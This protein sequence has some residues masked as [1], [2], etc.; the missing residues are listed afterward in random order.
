MAAAAKKI[1][2]KS[3]ASR[4]GP[5]KV[6]ISLHDEDVYAALLQLQDSLNEA[7]ARFNAHTHTGVTAG[8]GSTGTT[9]APITG[10]PQTATN[11]FTTP[12][13]T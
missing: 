8:A 9:S 2:R 4:P 12:A 11:L 3:G 10:T 13:T 1:R 5:G 7:I 6:Q